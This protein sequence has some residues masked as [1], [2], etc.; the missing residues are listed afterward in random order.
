MQMDLPL[1]AKK[2]HAELINKISGH[3]H[4]SMELEYGQ[5][6]N[7]LSVHL[8]PAERCPTHSLFKLLENLSR[9][10]KF[11]VGNYDILKSLIT[12]PEILFIIQNYEQK[13]NEIL[14]P[15]KVGQSSGSTETDSSA[16]PLRLTE[17]DLQRLASCFG[18]GWEMFVGQLGVDSATVEQKK[19][20]NPTHMPSQVYNC[21]LFWY[22]Q[23]RTRPTITSFHQTLQDSLDF[24]SV[25]MDKYEKLKTD[26]ENRRI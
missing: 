17:Q 1:E 18:S 16:D 5:F 11:G 23:G 4:P 25:N 13:I 26:I 22:R 7:S 15:D 6:L 8:M 12:D 3:L 19:I 2:L 10:G 14:Y 9:K 24:C 20:E 21:L